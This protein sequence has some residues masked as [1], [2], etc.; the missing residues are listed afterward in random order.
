MLLSTGAYAVTASQNGTV[1]ADGWL[2]VEDF[3]NKS[4]GDAMS[5]WNCENSNK[6]AT[7]SIVEDEKDVNNLAVKCENGNYGDL[8]VI[9][10]TLP[11]GKMMSDYKTIQ[12]D[13]SVW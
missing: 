13:I 3:Q 5:A 11:D 2:T 12:F 10:V 8:I 1:S 6:S 7:V 4:V 9:P